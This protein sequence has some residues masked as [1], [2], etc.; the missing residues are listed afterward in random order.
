MEKFNSALE[1]ITSFF[2]TAKEKVEKTAS[3]LTMLMDIGK[4]IYDR[5]G[6]KKSAKKAKVKTK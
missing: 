6:E 3:S 5:V 4:R 2:T 1:A